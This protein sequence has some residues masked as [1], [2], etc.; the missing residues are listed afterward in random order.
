MEGR[1]DLHALSPQKSG[2]VG[3]SGNFLA[4]SNG[5]VLLLRGVWIERVG[6]VHDAGG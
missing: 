3:L 5:K 2:P 1:N 6:L 4:A